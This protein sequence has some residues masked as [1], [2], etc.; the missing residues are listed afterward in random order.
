MEND[1]TETAAAQTAND[2]LAPEG[3]PTSQ[4]PPPPTNTTTTT[5]SFT[6]INGPAR[7]TTT[8]S[9]SANTRSR[10][11]NPAAPLRLPPLPRKPSDVTARLAALSA[12][13]VAELRPGRST[14]MDRPANV[15]AAFAQVVGQL[16]AGGQCR[17]CVGGH[18]P[19]R[20]CVVVGG[21]FG[22]SCANCHYNSEGQRCSFR[23]L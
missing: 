23:K 5:S 9:P 18:G 22:G 2:A 12:V 13:R 21:C 3:P 17:H 11:N 16:P 19:W 15:E 4:P 14:N 10:A 1:H 7:T 20:V 8:T 6:P